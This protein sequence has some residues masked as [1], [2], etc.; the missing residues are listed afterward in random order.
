MSQARRPALCSE[1]PQYAA[2]RRARLAARGLCTDC[3]KAPMRH[4]GSNLCQPCYDKRTPALR[5]RRERRK[6]ETARRRA[7]FGRQGWRDKPGVCGRCSA[8]AVATFD[9]EDGEESVCR[10]HFDVLT[11]IAAERGGRDEG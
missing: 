1:G 9:T 10:M 3:A 7:A 4:S 11:E 8:D 2:Q 5:A 6:A